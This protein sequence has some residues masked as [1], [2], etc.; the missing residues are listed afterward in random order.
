MRTFAEDYKF[1]IE[2]ENQQ[3]STLSSYFNSTLQKLSLTHAMDFQGESLFIELKTRTNAST[4]YPTTLIPY[5]KIEFAKSTSDCTYFVFCFTDGLFYIQYDEDQFS[6][7]ETKLFQRKG[8]DKKDKEQA[9]VYI[10]INCLT[11]I[12]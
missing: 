2:S 9:Y 4:T 6:T 5:S 10:P 8:R 3:I 11:K 1:G 7:F 12:V